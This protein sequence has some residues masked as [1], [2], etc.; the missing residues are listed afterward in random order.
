MTKTIVPFGAVWEE[1][2]AFL[3]AEL[4]LLAPLSLLGFGVP[5]VALLLAVPSDAAVDGNLQPGAWMIWMLPCG[6]ISMLGSIA[7]SALVL[8]P[9]ISVRESI[10]IAIRRVPA[11]A[12]LFL[13]YLALQIVLSLPLGL[14]GVLEGGRP[15]PL[16]MLVSLADL[17][18]TVWVFV[19]LLP[20]WAVVADRPRAPWVAIRHAFALTRSCYLKLLLLRIVMLMAVVVTMIVLLIP[21][22]A[23][24]RLIGLAAG[25]P[26]IGMVIAF[27]LMGALVSAIVGTWTV[28]VAL[29][30]R[31]L[32]A[33]SSGM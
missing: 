18:F 32:P 24:T 5:M 11:G 29:L 4:S 25:N 17:A 16:S 30:Y 7:V 26:D 10:G 13:L 6:L 33:A 19:R 3:R 14:I 28:Y 27:V 2:I 23:V 31:R 20:I 9:N 21:I 15:G 12:G 1:T 22:G 8:T